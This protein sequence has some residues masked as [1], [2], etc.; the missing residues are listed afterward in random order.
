MMVKNT[1]NSKTIS[2]E[3]DMQLSY[4]MTTKDG[5][6]LCVWDQRVDSTHL[7]HYVGPFKSRE[8]CQAYC[9]KY[10]AAWGMGYNGRSKPEN[11]DGSWY[12]YCVRWT[13]CD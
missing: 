8:E 12:A 1:T 10:D 4:E 5:E 3:N 11:I 2:T 6:T 9:D 13:S 7:R